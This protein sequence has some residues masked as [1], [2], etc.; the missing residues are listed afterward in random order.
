MVNKQYTATINVPVF[1]MLSATSTLL[2]GLFKPRQKMNKQVF[3]IEHKLDHRT[4]SVLE[5]PLR[6]VRS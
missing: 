3:K 5:E 6:L 2:S 4:L 1:H